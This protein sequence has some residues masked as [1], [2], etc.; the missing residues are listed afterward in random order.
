MLPVLETGTWLGVCAL[1]LAFAAAQGAALQHIRRSRSLL[2]AAAAA[3]IYLPATVLMLCYEAWPLG[4]RLIPVCLGA[5]VLALAFWRPVTLRPCW[6]RA[7]GLRYLASAMA[8]SALVQA[9]LAWAAPSAAA[10]ALATAA[11]LA[12]W[13]SLRGSLQP[14]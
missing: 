4:M 11:A 6:R 3:A 8:L 12:S 14:A 9:G 5:T 7:F 13:A 2:P 10:A 1:Y